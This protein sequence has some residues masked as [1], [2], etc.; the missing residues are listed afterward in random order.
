MK[1][2]SLKARDLTGNTQQARFIFLAALAATLAFAFGTLIPIVSAPVAAITALIAVRPTF[3]ESAQE[4]FRQVVG[5]VVG[6]ISAYVMI[7]IF[8]V[9]PIVVFAAVAASFIVAKLLRLGDEGAIT[10]GVTVILVIG[11][12]LDPLEV[13][14]RLLG[15]FVGCLMALLVS[16]YTRPG[17]P[18]QRALDET[19]SQADRVSQLL[20]TIAA[21]LPADGSKVPPEIAERWMEEAENIVRAS[22]KARAS[23]ENALAGSRWSPLLPK[24][25]A[26]AVLDQAG[27]T[28]ATAITVTN[29]C[30]DIMLSS[31]REE[32]LPAELVDSLSDVLQATAEVVSE[33]TEQAR[34][35]PAEPLPK[36]S[37]FIATARET[38]REAVSTLRDIDET[39]P[40]LIGGSLL[41]DATKI[42]DTLTGS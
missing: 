2:I 30:R 7:Q 29:I 8:G 6:G 38:K 12:T 17:T 4:G 32:N 10:T 11:F 31:S 27:I 26:K 15:V 34:E 33:Q 35:N 28:Y 37:E 16:L 19:L 39:Q 25:E 13:E 42:S 24:V 36:D 23:A 14:Y 20:G 41:R 1:K 9:S 3:H 40:I 18:H 5:V 22:E 21:G